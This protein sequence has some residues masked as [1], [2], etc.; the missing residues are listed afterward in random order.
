MLPRYAGAVQSE[1]IVVI[2]GSTAFRAAADGLRH[3]TWVL[4]DSSS[5]RSKQIVRAELEDIVAA[6]GRSSPIAWRASSQAASI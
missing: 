1:E 3:S 2:A 6:E 4:D 5:A